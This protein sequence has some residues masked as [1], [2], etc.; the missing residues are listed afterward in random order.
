[1]ALV[2]EHPVWN[3]VS[4]VLPDGLPAV[5]GVRLVL[6]G[7]ELS[8]RLAEECLAHDPVERLGRYSRLGLCRRGAAGFHGLDLG[9]SKGA[10][11]EPLPDDL[12]GISKLV[13][14]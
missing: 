2:Q 7:P 1:M 3:A 5:L 14:R 9:V 13:P 8:G 6:F 4:C 10:E 12:G 11:L